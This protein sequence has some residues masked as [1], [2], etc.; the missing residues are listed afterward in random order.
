VRCSENFPR[1]R[2]GRYLT[3]IHFVEINL[4][5]VLSMRPLN[6]GLT[7]ADTVSWRWEESLTFYG[8]RSS[9]YTETSSILEELRNWLE[10]I[11]STVS[12]L[13]ESP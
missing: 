1:R 11:L 3:A 13:Q 10:S 8:K 12:A 6:A 5:L 9:S 2:S 7:S 4:I